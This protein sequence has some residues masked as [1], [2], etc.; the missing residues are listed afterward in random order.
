MTVPG[1][2]SPEI[3]LVRLTPPGR[4]AVASLLLDGENADCLLAPLLDRPLPSQ[5]HPQ[6]FFARFQIGGQTEE[7]VL[8]LESTGRIRLHMHGGE[9]VLQ[10]VTD[11]LTRAGA[12]SLAPEA[13]IRRS[14]ADPVEAEAR[15]ALSRCRTERT[16][17]I[18][19]DQLGGAFSRAV[20]EGRY[21]EL[22]HWAPL[23]LH[24]TEPFRV[25]L[26]GL[27][28]SG[29][30]TLL[31]ALLGYE[32]GIVHAEPGTT[33]DPVAVRTALDG[34]PVLLIDTAG[35]RKSDCVLEQ[36]GMARVADT[37]RSADLALELI[38]STTGE[39][40]PDAHDFAGRPDPSLPRIII[41]S[42]SDLAPLTSFVDPDVL[43]VSGLTG[44]GIEALRRR[45]VR[46]LIPEEPAPG[47]GMPFTAEQVAMLT[48]LRNLC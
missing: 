29:K 20:R 40:L 46:E 45:I 18:M 48:S 39:R 3:F 14:I 30:S 24:L 35:L 36:A 26:I 2:V 17:K 19:L 25:V 23:G 32:R 5:N 41:A 8:H 16:V 4:G 7:L 47:Q 31:N 34:W 21:A 13:W 38:D 37:L 28:N 44:T 1:H 33:R 27:P 22:L 10:A 12:F 9:A 42:K 15:I 11:Q 6:P 43:S